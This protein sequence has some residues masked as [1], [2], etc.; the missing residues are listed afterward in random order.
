MEGEGK[1]KEKKG[2]A[3][4]KEKKGQAQRLTK[5]IKGKERTGAAIDEIDRFGI[6]RRKRKDRRSD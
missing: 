1:K 6:I 3:Q 5:L 4:K 2:Q